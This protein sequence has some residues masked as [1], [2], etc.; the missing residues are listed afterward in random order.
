MIR[1]VP[2][3]MIAL[4]TIALLL[5]PSVATAQVPFT[6]TTVKTWVGYDGKWQI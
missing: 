3:A 1:Y 2:G 4:A 6:A 5:L